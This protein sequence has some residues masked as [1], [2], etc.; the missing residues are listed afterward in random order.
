VFLGEI[1]RRPAAI[2][3]VAE[4]GDIARL[5]AWARQMGLAFAVRSG[6][7]SAAQC[8]AVGSAAQPQ[9]LPGRGAA[10]GG[11]LTNIIILLPTQA[12]A[13]CWR[14]RSRHSGP[15][16]PWGAGSRPPLATRSLA[17]L[18]RRPRGKARPATAGEDSPSPAGR[19]R[20]RAWTGTTKPGRSIW[21]G[22]APREAALGRS[23][24][25]AM[26][27][28]RARR[29]EPVHPRA[30]RRTQ[31]PSHP[32][33]PS[34]LEARSRRL[35]RAEVGAVCDR[36]EAGGCP[37]CLRERADE[38]RP[39]PRDRA[40]RLDPTRP[41][42]MARRKPGPAGHHH[43]SLSTEG[44]WSPAAGLAASREGSILRRPWP[45]EA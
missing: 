32:L 3:E 45:R 38:C 1:G 4:T 13:D 10:G 19:S 35:V 21:D 37:N 16:S 26:P 8:G 42:A 18:Q 7:R 27:T 5:A 9:G 34:V 31:G 17:R 6:G 43:G 11:K 44:R 24:S 12:Q 20:S 29:I 28:D 25:R 33:P 39:L 30:M 36:V 40:S 14:C 41:S 23:G 22:L 15:R 2:V